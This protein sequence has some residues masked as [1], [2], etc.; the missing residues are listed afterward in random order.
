MDS[1]DRVVNNDNESSEVENGQSRAAVAPSQTSLSD[2]DVSAILQQAKI[3]NNNTSNPDDGV[4][5]DD[6]ELVSAVG[7][8][9]AILART[10]EKENDPVANETEDE[11]KSRIQDLITDL[12]KN[13]GAGTQ[14]VHIHE[15]LHTDAK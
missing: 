1:E 6:M 4:G 2:I 12:V 3:A 9:S 5:L 7:R 11:R 8:V 13:G 10:L 14:H 15:Y